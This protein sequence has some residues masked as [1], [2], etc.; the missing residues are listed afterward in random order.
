MLKYKE[1]QILLYFVNLKIFKYLKESANL[2]SLCWS[3][4]VLPV[5]PNLE[6]PENLDPVEPL[7][8]LENLDPV[9]LLVNL[10]S[11]SWSR[12]VLPVPPSLE[13]PENLDPVVELLESSENLE[14]MK[15]WDILVST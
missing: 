11:L 6:P 1:T 3:R 5:P 14:P 15:G 12:G 10:V 2:V 7:L 4:G 9:E 8:L 13:P